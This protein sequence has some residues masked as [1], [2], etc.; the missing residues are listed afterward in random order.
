M[1]REVCQLGSAFKNGNV[2][3]AKT[4]KKGLPRGR[5]RGWRSLNT[6]GMAFPCRFVFGKGGPFLGEG[7]DGTVD[8]IVAWVSI[9]L[10]AVPRL[11]SPTHLRRGGK[12][13]AATLG[14]T[15]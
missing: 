13:R 9:N 14:M 7:K 15:E 5:K 3:E 6:S 12:G 1:S 8:V 2:S 11:R 10:A 4:E